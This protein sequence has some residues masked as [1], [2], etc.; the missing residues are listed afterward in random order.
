M[1]SR[2]ITNIKYIK[3]AFTL[4]LGNQAVNFSLPATDG[5]N[6]SLGDFAD[7]RFLVVFLRVTTVLTSLAQMN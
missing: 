2:R 1:F 4:Q 3:M 7:S 5:K 6:Y